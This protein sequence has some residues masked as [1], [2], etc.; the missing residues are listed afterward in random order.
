[1]SYCC[2]FFLFISNFFCVLTSS[3]S[4]VQL[5]FI[6]LRTCFFWQI[7]RIK[8]RV[9]QPNKTNSSKPKH[10]KRTK[11]IR[12]RFGSHAD[13]DRDLRNFSFLYL[14]ERYLHFSFL[15]L[16]NLFNQMALQKYLMCAMDTFFPMALQKERWFY[17]RKESLKDLGT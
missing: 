17:W 9:D 1:M 3:C 15:K 12:K 8:N 5:L 16:Q 11:T 2:W 6:V 7:R 13:Q 4:M 14:M 10:A